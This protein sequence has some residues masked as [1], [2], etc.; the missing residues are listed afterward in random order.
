MALQTLG[1]GTTEGDGT[2]DSIRDGGDKIND[3]F[4]EI[5]TLLGTGTALSSGIS[6]TA[7]VVTLAAPSITGVASFADGSVSAPA[8]T[9]T[10]DSNTGIFFSAADTVSVTTGGTKRVD[11]DSSG[12]DVTGAITATTTITGTTL[13]ATGDTAAG[14]NAAIGFTAAEGLILTGQGSTSDITLKNDADAIVFTVPT[15]TDDILFPDNAKVMLGAGSDLQIYHDGSNSLIDDTGTGSLFLRSGLITLSGA[16]GGETMAT[17]TDDGA[18]ALFHNNV[19][20]FATVSGGVSVTG[21]YTGTGLMTTGGSIVIPNAG[22]IGSVG[23]TDSIAIASDGVVTFSQSPVFPDG[24]IPLADLDIDG[25]TDIGAAIV[26]ADLFIIDDGAGGANRKVA[27]SRIATYIGGGVNTPA[28]SATKSA[29]TTGQGDNV[30]TKITFD[31]ELVD[32]DGKFA[33]SRF[34][35]TV[36]GDYFI[37]G[38]ASGG[39][40]S[41]GQV[42]NYNLTIFK[43][44]A[45]ITGANSGFKVEQEMEVVTAGV[46]CIIT[47]DT[48][49]Y[50]ELFITI[51]ITAGTNRVTNANFSGFKIIA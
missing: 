47:L 34:T 3:N 21:T 49:D 18:V 5:Y 25:A 17:F 10:G 51:N 37:A 8:I 35:P 13:E 38:D 46:S 15:G 19:V 7:T 48:D 20:K 30:A 28:F 23:D 32:S 43:N 24:S 40:S 33:S 9:N 4:S 2:G 27:A 12:L 26:D 16:G 45:A 6:A 41:Q 14:D 42:T 22:N 50:V 36:A 44:G 1:L 39:T 11:I 31:T 29:Q